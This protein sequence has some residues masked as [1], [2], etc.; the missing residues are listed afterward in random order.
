MTK[1]ITVFV[2]VLSIFFGGCGMQ[3][4]YVFCDTSY[5]NEVECIIE[6]KPDQVTDFTLEFECDDGLVQI[7]HYHVQ[8]DNFDVLWLSIPEHCVFMGVV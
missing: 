2:L 6:A 1:I 5:F 7:P 4:S 8:E 3:E